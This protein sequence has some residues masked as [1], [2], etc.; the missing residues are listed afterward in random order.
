MVRIRSFKLFGV[1]LA[2][3]DMADSRMRKEPAGPVARSPRRARRLRKLIYVALAAVVVPALFFGLLEGGLRL[4]GYGYRTAFLIRKGDYYESN[5]RFGWRFFPPAISRAPS[6]IRLPVNKPSGTYRI[7]VIGGSAAM[8]YPDPT[9]SFSRFLEAMLRDRFPHVRFEIAN[10]AITAAN[11]H[12]MVPVARE[13]AE[14]APDLFIV[15]MG[16]N[17]VVG[18]FGAGSTLANHSPGLK[19]IRAGLWLKTIRVGQLADNLLHSSGNDPI[20]WRGME[21]FLERRVP[22]DDPRLQRVYGN[23]R[24]NLEDIC[25]AATSRGTNVLLCT[26]PVNLRHSA[27]FASVHRSDLTEGQ[28]GQWTGHYELGIAAEHVGRFGQAVEHFSSALAID[29]RYA[30]LHFRLGRCYLQLD[31]PD[32]AGEHFR[33]AREFDALRFR[34]DGTINKTIRKVAAAAGEKVQLVDVER[35]FE[36]AADVVAASPG[37]ELF[38][39]HVHLNYRGN[40]E[41]AAAVFPE[42]IGQLPIA[43]EGGDGVQPPS[44]ERCAQRLALTNWTRQ[45]NA[46]QVWDLTSRA[47]FVNQLNYAEARRRMLARRETLWANTTTMSKVVA[48][49]RQALADTPDDAM[50]HLLAARAYGSS[51]DLAAAGKHIESAKRLLPGEPRVHIVEARVLLHQGKVAEAKRAAEAHLDLADHTVP[52]YETVI[53]MFRS[54]QRL[55]E[56]EAFAR[57]AVRRLGERPAVLMLLAGILKEQQEISQAESLLR[58]AIAMDAGHTDAWILLG[59]VLRADRRAPEAVQAFRKA[60]ELDPLMTAPYAEIGDILFREG[61]GERAKPYLAKAIELRP[62]HL[63]ATGEYAEILCWE[64][65]AAEGAAYYRRALRINPG[66]A[67]VAARLAWVLATS[68]DPQV[69]NSKEAVRLAEQAVAASGGRPQTMVSLAAAYAADGEFDKAVAV[70]ASAL[71]LA[72]QM[73]DPSLAQRLGDHLSRYK[74][75]Q[76]LSIEF[77]D[78]IEGW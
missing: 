28:L 76:S 23:F 35:V 19:A 74:K 56:A 43:A 77:Y 31:R 53:E 48:A 22:A 63:G 9:Y 52:S 49:C 38:F 26:V 69:R 4:F 30:D 27:P 33:Q 36:T 21:M 17:E 73:R 61:K 66:L 60:I 6:A 12:M 59:K 3:N 72:E 16:N 39:E 11:S 41:L 58:Q 54:Q 51:G 70:A 55:T 75:S 7:F 29:D 15:Y 24:R 40:Y 57:Q 47:P 45:S 5:L 78:R 2:T 34:A 25:K 37:E 68:S 13:C 65:R 42:V 8:G 71:S 32:R 10:V 18:P 67:P 62:D 64:G 1:P 20:V 46:L 14:A 50:L 44:Y